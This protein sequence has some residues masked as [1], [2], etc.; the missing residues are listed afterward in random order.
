MTI[1]MP[2][3][4]ALMIA[5]LG[6]FI[7]GRESAPTSLA[8]GD[9]REDAADRYRSGRHPGRGLVVVRSAFS[10]EETAAR[11]AQA[12]SAG[13]ATVVADIDHAAAAA[14][15]GL[16]LRP[17]RVLLIGNPAAGT[18]LMQASQT[19]GIDLPLKFLIYQDARGRVLLTYNSARYLE[20]RHRIRGQDKLLRRIEDTQRG[21]AAAATGS[22]PPA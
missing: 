8:A 3:G 5:V 21:L 14:R 18:P 10:A 4:A 6:A 2:I 1:R 20:R 11:L 13:G 22:Q 17:T 9:P 19:T 15:A 12:A 16:E 7:V